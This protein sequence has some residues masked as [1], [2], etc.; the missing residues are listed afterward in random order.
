MTQ[1]GTNKLKLNFTYG[2][3]NNN[4]NVLT[5]TITPPGITALTQTY[6][7]DPLNRIA[8]AGESNGTTT[9]SR[10]YGYDPYGNRAVIG[11]SG[12]SLL[13]V[14]P[15]LLTDFSTAS[16]RITMANTAYDPAGN[17][18]TT[19][20]NEALVY[21]AENRQTSYTGGS[22]SGTYFYDGNGNRVKKV[23]TESGTTTTQ[24]FVYDAFGKLAAEYSDRAPQSPGTHYRTIDHLGST[25][26]VTDENQADKARYDLLPF[27]E[28]IFA[29]VGGRS[30]AIGYG[31]SLDHRHKFTGKERDSESGMD[32]FGARY[33]S[34]SLGR[35]TSAD[36]PFADQYASSPQSWN[37]Y[38]YVRNNPLRFIDP[39]GNACVVRNDRSTFDDDSGGQTCAEVDAD[40]V[41]G[42]STT[43]SA[44][45]PLT[46]LPGQFFVGFGEFFLNGQPQG[47]AVMGNALAVGA[48]LEL[49]F[50]GTSSANLAVVAASRAGDDFL[51]LAAPRI[52]R[53]VQGAKL[54]KPGRGFSASSDLR[55]GRRFRSSYEGFPIAQRDRED[56]GPGA[57]E[58]TR[59]WIKGS[60]TKLQQRHSTHARDPACHRG[61]DKNPVQLMTPITEPLEVEEYRKLVGAM[62]LTQE[63][64]CEFNANWIS[65]R[66][67][68]VVPV[69]SMARL[70]Q[71]DI[72]RL[73][74]ALK[75]GSSHCVA[76]ATEPLGD[77]PGYYLVSIDETDFLAV[78]REL[79]LFR[80][81]L[82]DGGRSWAISCTEWYN[83]FAAQPALLEAM[84]GKSI[85]VAR[86]EYVRFASDLAEKSDE[87]LL[88]VASHYASL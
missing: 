64:A 25:R 87:P 60:P 56:V 22:S 85:D 75:P 11:W 3:T 6:T 12:I 80:F 9:W 36:A 55:E 4:S 57:G 54:T 78:N 24:I 1:G 79:G 29:G 18:I 8:T 72:P 15:K 45:V 70:P 67:W 16:N 13:A 35:F 82:T 46:D 32:Y 28:E 43:T 62:M 17:L 7:Y 53:I 48:G 86:E 38:G 74:S 23:S 19:H 42:E 2:T 47:A 66:G 77:M 52:A 69:E 51:R 41:G 81:L 71:P 10:T 31:S 73:A 14:T 26:L 44:T 40:P 39:S 84:L 59:R 37:L 49:V 76:V 88:Q 21:D 33:F 58:S 65:E 20:L 50:L 61:S 30:G 68:K 34:A 27:G 83:L 63:E 5:Q